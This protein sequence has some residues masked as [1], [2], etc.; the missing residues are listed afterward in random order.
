M[1]PEVDDIKQRINNFLVK[2]TS[3][4]FDPRK[5]VKGKY[6]HFLSH[7]A[8]LFIFLADCKLPKSDLDHIFDFEKELRQ[9]TK[10]Y[11]H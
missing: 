11:L 4:D 2:E 5:S 7:R 8:N 3:D 6:T 9:S 10:V 1:D